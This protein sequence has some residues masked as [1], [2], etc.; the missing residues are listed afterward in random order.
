MAYMSD[1]SVP[2]GLKHASFWHIGKQ[3]SILDGANLYHELLREMPP[4]EKPATG[5]AEDMHT[6]KCLLTVHR[7]AQRRTARV[8]RLVGTARGTDAV[9]AY[10]AGHVAG[11]VHPATCG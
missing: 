11:A 1:M 2:Q 5:G 4:G 10:S 8:V 9:K 7:V 6:I 3:K